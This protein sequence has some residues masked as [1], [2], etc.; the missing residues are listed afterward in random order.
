MKK[1]HEPWR[2]DEDLVGSCWSVLDSRGAMVAEN[3]QRKELA[4]L[5]ASAPEMLDCLYE[6]QEVQLDDGDNRPYWT[7]S[8]RRLGD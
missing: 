1:L 7:G 3:I 4:Q 8:G 5:I 2:I 6:S